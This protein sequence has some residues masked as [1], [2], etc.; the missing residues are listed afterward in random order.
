[1]EIIKKVKLLYN[2]EP[3]EKTLSF[4]EVSYEIAKDMMLKNHYSHKWNT[5]FGKINIGVFENDILYG[6]ASFGNLMNPKSFKNIN[7]DFTQ[8]NVIE[9]NR[10]WVDDHLG[11]NTETIL[12][13][14]S[15]KI[16]REK[17]PEIKAVQSFADGRLGVGTIYKASNFNYYGYTETLFYENVKTKEVF[18]NVPFDNTMRPDG[19]IKLN[20]M[21]IRNELKSFLVKTYKY[22]MPLYKNVK[23]D[24]EQLEYP[25][26]DKG[27]EYVETNLK[28]NTMARSFILSY[29]LDYNEYYDILDWAKKNK[30]I[31]LSSLSNES[32]VK[33]CE[34]RK[35]DELYNNLLKDFEIIFKKNNVDEKNI[36]QQMSIFDFI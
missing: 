14:V 33:I 5:S 25:K 2:D 36:L 8:D 34:Q 13:S 35:K 23:I 32:I 27:L 12:L 30:E 20:G 21:L 4:K 3:I 11:K 6:I 31:I 26:Y 9:L 22:I 24:L 1:M 15:W 7:K 29:I 10:L 16:I 17:Y 28:P 18:H 19:M